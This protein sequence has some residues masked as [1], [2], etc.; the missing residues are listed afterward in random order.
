MWYMGPLKAPTW[1]IV[2]AT[3]VLIAVF[4]ALDAL[5]VSGV[6]IAVLAVITLVVILAIAAPRRARDLGGP[7][8][9]DPPEKP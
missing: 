8:M 1:R 3:L 7:G 2:L 4:G 6:I 5:G 9:G